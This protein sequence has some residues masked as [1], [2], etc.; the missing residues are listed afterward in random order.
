MKLSGIRLKGL[1]CLIEENDVRGIRPDL[2]DRMR[3]TPVKIGMI[4][5][6]PGNFIRTEVLAELGP[7]KSKAAGILGVRDATLSDLVNSKSSL[8]PEMALR[9]EKALGGNMD[10]LLKMQAWFDSLAMR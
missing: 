2:L 6:H 8:S 4:P 9:I 5:S 10:M 3:K 1:R 7:S